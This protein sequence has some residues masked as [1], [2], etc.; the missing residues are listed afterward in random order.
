MIVGTWYILPVGVFRLLRWLRRGRWCRVTRCYDRVIALGKTDLTILAIEP[1]GIRKARNECLVAT[2][3]PPELA[4]IAHYR[5]MPM[6]V[7]Q[8]ADRVLG[9]QFHPESIMTTEGARLLTQSL[10][11]V[12]ATDDHKENHHA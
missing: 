10:R 9:F 4:V 8:R 6:A 7:L 5:D 12:T 3:V 1:R 11:F 2:Y